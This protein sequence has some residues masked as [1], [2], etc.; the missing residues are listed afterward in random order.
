MIIVSSLEME[1]TTD[2]TELRAEDKVPVFE[3]PEAPSL[4]S[5]GVTYNSMEEDEV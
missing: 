2:G 4:P 1:S 3:M 5:E